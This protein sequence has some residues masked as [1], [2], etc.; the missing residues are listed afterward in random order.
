MQPQESGR[1]GGGRDRPPWPSVSVWAAAQPAAG[2]RSPAWGL[3]QSLAGEPAVL[4]PLRPQPAAQAEVL[5]NVRALLASS[6]Q[7][8]PALWHEPGA[9]GD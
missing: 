9:G 3:P 6:R 4:C 8:F 7:W 5:S 1:A 2:A